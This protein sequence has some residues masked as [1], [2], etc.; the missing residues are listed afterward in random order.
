VI[1]IYVLLMSNR[2]STQSGTTGP[3]IGRSLG[4]LR[5][6]PLTGNTSP[7]VLE[8][9]QGRVTLINF[10]G[11]W[12]PPCIRE[13]PEIADLS[14][15]FASHDAF[16]LYAV[17]CGQQDDADLGVLREETEMFLQSRGSSL[18]TYADQNGATRQAMTLTLGISLAYPTT[19]VLDRRGTV[20]GFWQGYVPG[21]A[22]EMGELIDKLL[23]ETK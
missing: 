7:V 4:Y 20:R 15:R 12:C 13:L 8:D 14:K 23:A 2:G 21:A 16:R 18:P 9:L 22:D 10:W 6:E 11:T 17:S 1:F 5:F 3:A 19:L